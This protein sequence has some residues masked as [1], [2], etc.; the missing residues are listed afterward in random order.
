MR[1]IH[2]INEDFKFKQWLIDTFIVNDGLY[3]PRPRIK[4]KDGFSMSVQGGK[5][6]YSKPREHST[7]YEEMEIGYPSEYE[8]LI[9]DYAEH[10]MDNFSYT[11][12][13]YPYVP[14]E[15]IIKVIKKHG[16]MEEK[17]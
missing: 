7:K 10:N 6:V 4:C 5:Y 1:T 14:V 3:I 11:D 16:G 12:T 17:K 9:R 2:Q 15:L 8:E 13:V